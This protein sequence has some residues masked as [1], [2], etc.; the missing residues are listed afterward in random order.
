MEYNALLT[1]FKLFIGSQ[2]GNQLAHC[3]G[4]LIWKEPL[5][6][7]KISNHRRKCKHV[8]AN[9]LVTQNLLC[10]GSSS[11]VSC[12]GTAWNN[13]WPGGRIWPA[14]RIFRT[15]VLSQYLINVCMVQKI[16]LI[17]VSSFSINV[18]RRAHRS[19]DTGAK[20]W[21]YDPYQILVLRYVRNTVQAQKI[22]LSRPL[23]RV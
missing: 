13:Y 21:L 18:H 22:Y 15:C 8:V 10:S 5:K 14:E 3:W 20:T 4:N 11:T 23:P 6:I 9:E 17:L 19:G 12:S 2:T 1:T 7:S 16:I